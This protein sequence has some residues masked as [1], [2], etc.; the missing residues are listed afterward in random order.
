ML[1]I[2]D[3]ILDLAKIESGKLTTERIP[4]HLV[5]M[6]QDVASIVSIK[7][8]SK[9]LAFHIEFATSVPKVIH[10]D[11]V[12]LRQILINL[13]GNAIKFTE[14]GAVT[15]RVG[16]ATENQIYFEVIDTGIGLTEEQQGRLFN[17]FIQA[18]AS[19][20]RRFG[21]SGLGLQISKNLAELL[22]GDITIQSQL[23][24]GSTF[25]FTTATGSLTNIEIIDAISPAQ[26]SQVATA[27]KPALQHPPISLSG[28]R[29]MVM[30]DGPDNQKLIAFLLERA[31]AK[32]TL[33]DNGRVGIEAMKV[34]GDIDSP[35]DP[36][37]PY[38][39]ILTDMQ[40]PELNGYSATRLLREKGCQ[41]PI[42]ALTAFAMLGDLDNCLAAGCDD[43]LA[44]PINK[45]DLF[46]ICEK[47]SESARS[48]CS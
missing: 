41:L 44:K 31:G 42:I 36:G 20:T 26:I 12:R 37:A 1:V 21:G 30:E 38:D 17:A 13:L 47:W 40:M 15:L 24:I 4:V 6:I 22:G 33:F 10:S 27:P 29:I 46:A 25:R 9:Q 3:D 23:G 16:M 5:P 2:I 7:A 45:H 14:A 43:Y 19:T 32:V 35:L 28:L 34:D 11:Q 8:L 48:V 18:D 39:L